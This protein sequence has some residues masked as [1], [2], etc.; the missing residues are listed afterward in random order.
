MMTTELSKSWTKFWKINRG[1]IP[2]GAPLDPLLKT[3]KDM[4]QLLLEEAIDQKSV[5]RGLATDTYTWQYMFCPFVPVTTG[6][7]S[8]AG[9]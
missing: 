5:K 6:F 9:H 3:G 4:A 1:I 2:S 8:L 7:E